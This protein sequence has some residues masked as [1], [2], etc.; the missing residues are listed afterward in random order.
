[1]RWLNS[2]KKSRFTSGPSGFSEI[3]FR[4]PRGAAKV[5][6]GS[7]FLVRFKIPSVAF[8]DPSEV[9]AKEV[10][11]E[12]SSGPIRTRVASGALHPD[13]LWDSFPRQSDRFGLQGRQ[14]IVS[15]GRRQVPRFASGPPG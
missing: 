13:S 7:C 6:F 8:A 11:P 15:G 12:V 1:M 4:G 10:M 9:F 5:H 3:S 2:L 14:S